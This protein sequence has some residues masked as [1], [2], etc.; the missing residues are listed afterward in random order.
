M[1]HTNLI[2]LSTYQIVCNLQFV[3]TVSVIRRSAAW[4]NCSVDFQRV[5][6]YLFG[7][8]QFSN[9]VSW[10]YNSSLNID[11]DQYLESSESSTS[12]I[13]FMS[14]KLLSCRRCNEGVGACFPP[15]AEGAALK[16]CSLYTSQFQSALARAALLLTRHEA[17][18]FIDVVFALIGHQCQVKTASYSARNSNRILEVALHSPLYRCILFRTL[19]SRKENSDETESRLTP[20]CVASAHC[21]VI[22]DPVRVARSVC[23]STITQK[24]YQF[25]A[26]IA[27]PAAG[28][29]SRCPSR[30]NRAY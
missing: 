20:Y 27:H 18:L 6:I 4:Y 14:C 17:P 5:A 11:V 30:T 23:S 13:V 8:W 29:P 26:V 15:P 16:G 19:T 22:K 10:C 25:W 7:V 2:Q 24:C 1:K 28:G 9:F 3:G 21:C 12:F